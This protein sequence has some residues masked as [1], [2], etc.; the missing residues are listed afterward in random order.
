[1]TTHTLQVDPEY[2]NEIISSPNIILVVESPLG[3]DIYIRV[4]YKPYVV[5]LVQD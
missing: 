5:T 3:K 4:N 1:M 2:Q